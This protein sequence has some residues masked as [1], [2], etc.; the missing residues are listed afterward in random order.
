[1]S[2]LLCGCGGRALSQ[3]EIVRGVLFDRQ[4]GGYS[5][6]LVLADQNAPDG[7]TDANKIACAAG[8]TPAQALQNAENSLTGSVYYGLLDL[9][10][11]PSDLDW[12]T[13]Q[14]VGMLLYENAQPAP[15]LSVFV[16]DEDPARSWAEEGTALYK[17]MKSLEDTAKIHCGL[18]QLFTQSEVCAVPGYNAAGGYDLVLL[19][20]DGVPL[21]C[22]GLAWAQLAAVLC[23]QTT[24]MQ[25]S[26]ADGAAVCTARTNVTVQNGT[27]QLHLRE[28]EL[29]ALY[30]GDIDLQARLCEELQD[31]FSFLYRRMQSAGADPF[32]LAFWQANIYGP[33]AV[34][35][36]VRL[37]ITFE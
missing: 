12:L 36:Q 8:D 3:R 6:C 10:A 21:R 23:G 7:Q 1:M 5:V 20:R 15:E 27:V 4:S 29:R 24:R 30:G 19:P 34:P 33:G 37:E 32:H 17:R 28:V 2:L 26:Y 14:E 25:G 9:A 16:L 11:L 13:A 22:R 18:Q 31:G 35:E